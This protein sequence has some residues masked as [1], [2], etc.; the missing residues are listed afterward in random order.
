MS[1][2]NRTV[3]GLYG[4][5]TVAGEIGCE[6]EVEG[7]RLPG[8]FIDPDTGKPPSDLRYHWRTHNDASLRANNVGD[9]TAEYVLREPVDRDALGKVFD[10]FDKHWKTHKA[11]SYNTYRTS[12]HVHLNV[13]Q[14]PMRK[15]YAFITAYMIL[16]EVLV[17]FADGGTGY[18][19]G[20]RFCLRAKDA[21]YI[22]T[23]LQQAARQEFRGRFDRRTLKYGALNIAALSQYGSLEFRALRGTVD[24][25]LIRKWISLLLAVK[26]FSER[27][28]TPNQ[29][30]QEFSALGPDKFLRA[31]FGPEV[32]G[33]LGEDQ[34]EVGDQLFD[35]M[36]LAQDV[37]FST[38]WVVGEVVPTKTP[39]SPRDT[40]SMEDLVHRAIATR[41]TGGWD[42]TTPHPIFVEPTTDFARTTI[43]NLAYGRPI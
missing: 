36:R 11:T 33:E 5:P 17:D 37:A 19:K 38:E 41:D 13:S 43:R 14:W 1:R 26:D 18:R 7:T 22:I 28:E 34:R 39:P 40:V 21:E 8:L 31:V 25:S 12:V 2:H 20:N 15:V 6:I 10:Y 29:I 35:G 27:F 9:M 24:T 42:I 23:S 4:T 32:A 16:E 3:Q 30:V